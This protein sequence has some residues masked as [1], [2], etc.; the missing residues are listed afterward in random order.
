MIARRIC[1]VG[2]I[3]LLIYKKFTINIQSIKFSSLSYKVPTFAAGF[4][5]KVYITYEH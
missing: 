2:I 1:P 3:L 4:F 5:D